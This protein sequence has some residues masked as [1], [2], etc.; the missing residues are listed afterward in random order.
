MPTI[1]IDVTAQQANRISAAFGKAWNL[2]DGAGEPRTA[3][4]AELRKFLIDQLAG[5]VYGIEHKETVEAVQPP[6]DM[7]VE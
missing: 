5:V 7:G 4:L 6:T 2:K 3:T 1:T